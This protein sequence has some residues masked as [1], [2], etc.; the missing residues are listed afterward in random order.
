MTKQFCNQPIVNK[1]VKVFISYEA[2]DL[3][4]KER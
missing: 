4:L 3:I 1:Y 2:T